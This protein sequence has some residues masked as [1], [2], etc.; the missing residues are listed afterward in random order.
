MPSENRPRPTMLPKRC[1]GVSGTMLDVPEQE[2][3]G[4]R[5]LPKFLSCP[6]LI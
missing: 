6:C 5:L 2:R 1:L 4:V 3:V